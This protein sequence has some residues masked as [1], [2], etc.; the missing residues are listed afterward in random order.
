[1]TLRGVDDG[2]TIDDVAVTVCEVPTDAPEPDGTLAWDAT[3]VVLVEAVAAG[4]R[5]M[6]VR[7]PGVRHSCRPHA[8]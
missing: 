5:G 3:T 1:M 4:C 8:A 7:Q 6:D 2:L